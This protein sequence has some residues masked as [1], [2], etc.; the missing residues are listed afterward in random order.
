MDQRAKW[1]MG[2]RTPVDLCPPPL[3]DPLKAGT[4]LADNQ[5]EDEEKRAEELEVHRSFNQW[6]I[7]CHFLQLNVGYISFDKGFFFPLSKRKCTTSGIRNC[8]GASSLFELLKYLDFS[9]IN[10][11]AFLEAG[12]SNPLDLHK[13]GGFKPHL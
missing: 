9:W 3:S 11:G 1:G 10:V 12:L 6:R 8:L 4:E 7:L 2:S 5:M 13:G